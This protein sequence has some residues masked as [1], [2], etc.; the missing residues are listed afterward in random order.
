MVKIIIIIIP[1]I[2]L[3]A[4]LEKYVCTNNNK[5]RMINFLGSETLYIQSCVEKKVEVMLT[6]YQLKVL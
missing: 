1:E 2:Y 5:N 4:T 3:L 6:W